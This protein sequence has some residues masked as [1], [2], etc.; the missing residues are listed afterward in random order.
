M[1][2]MQFGVYEYVGIHGRG[3]EQKKMELPAID[4]HV[5][6]VILVSV[7]CQVAISSSMRL[8]VVL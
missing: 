2:Q 4:V 7:K 3:F 6:C 5:M 1:I 8:N